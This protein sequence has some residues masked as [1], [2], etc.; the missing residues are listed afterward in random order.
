[1]TKTFTLI[2]L[3]AWASMIVGYL[4]GMLD[5]PPTMVLVNLLFG[6]NRDNLYRYTCYAYFTWHK[7]HYIPTLQYSFIMSTNWLYFARIWIMNKFTLSDIYWTFTIVL[8][9]YTKTNTLQVTF[10]T[11]DI[12]TDISWWPL[13][14]HRGVLTIK[15]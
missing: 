8:L 14:R 2:F 1:M 10:S 12:Y 4:F 11:Y 15:S 13:L 3:F 5:V 6:W 7:C 9:R